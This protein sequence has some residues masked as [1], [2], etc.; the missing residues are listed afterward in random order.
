MRQVFVISSN[1]HS[2]LGLTTEENFTR[3]LSGESAVKRHLLKNIHEDEI[4]ASLFSNDLM[5]LIESGIANAELFSKF[6]SLLISS[7]QEALKHTD[8][9]PSSPNTV[10]ICSTTKGSI[11][12]IE[13]GGSASVKSLE[14]FTSAKKLSEYFNNP[15]DP[16]V[17]SNACI[18]GLAALIVA[19][20]L[21]KSG[22]YE[23]AIVVGADTIGPFVYSGFHSFQA[24][25]SGPCK[26]FSTDRDGINLGEAAG[27][28]ILSSNVVHFNKKDLVRIGSGSMSNDANHI[29]GPSR[30][31]EELG[32]AIR[33]AMKASSLIPPDIGLVSA[34]GTATLYNDEMEAKALHFS[35]LED[36][37][38]NSL[39]GYF[40]HTLGAAGLIE[41]IIS[42]ESIKK[43]LILPSAGFSKAG[44]LPEVNV[45]QEVLEREYLHCLKIASGFGGCNAAIIYS[46][47]SIN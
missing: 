5:N 19:E 18:S 47:N 24:L 36:V 23:N 22:Q 6:E 45:C 27:T 21:L 9:D 12:E 10:F 34:H 35:G 16:I 46:K 42:I 13:N 41:S 43:G 4:W 44:L 26:P 2:P 29:S 31:G 30:T 1:I 11:S 15:N 17:I 37:P 32:M 28:M 33:K 20:R 40:G 14:L 39:K 3:L 8:V 25:S 38:L 7:A